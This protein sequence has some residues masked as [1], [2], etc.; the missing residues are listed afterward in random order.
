MRATVDPKA[1]RGRAIARAAAIIRAGGV[2]AYPTETFYALG[3][4]A[5]HR[6]AWLRVFALKG[7]SGEKL[8]PLIVA[9]LEQARQLVEVSPAVEAVAKRFWPGPLTLVLPVL[10]GS[11]PGSGAAATLA[12]RVSG[13]SIA[14][15]LARLA[16]PVTATSA[17]RSG[18]AALSSASEVEALFGGGVDLVLDGGPTPGGQASTIVDL[19]SN[20]PKLLREGPIPLEEVWKTFRPS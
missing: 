9:D 5:W 13:S 12:V 17:N 4:S 3:A 19:T 16:G 2:V 6:E 11:I 8:F 1:E 10:P 14:R 20:V 18:E 15:A 7:R